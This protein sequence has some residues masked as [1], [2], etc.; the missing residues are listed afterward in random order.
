[1]T[2]AYLLTILFFSVICATIGLA[3]GDLGKK[4]NGW[5]GFLLGLFLGPIGW[6]IVA[7]LPPSAEESDDTSK[8][9]MDPLTKFT[10]LGL[11]VCSIALIGLMVL[12]KIV[13]SY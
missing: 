4:R 1:M 9:K 2:T 7:V 3:I 10:L 6:I 13:T 12:G 5:T 11:A 8:T